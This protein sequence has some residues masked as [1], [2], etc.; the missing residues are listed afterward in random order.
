MGLIKN[1]RLA[2][3]TLRIVRTGEYCTAGE[4]VT[5]PTVDFAAVE[6]VSPD[7]ECRALGEREAPMCRFEVVNADSFQAAA[8]LLRPLVMNFANAH[9]AGGGAGFRV[10]R[11]MKKADVQSA[12]SVDGIAS[13]RSALSA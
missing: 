6:V 9:V 5:L 8:D 4:R 2:R 1:L 11:W 10:L 12:K 7:L 3:E 13:V